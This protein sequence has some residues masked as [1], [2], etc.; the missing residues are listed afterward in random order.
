MLMAFLTRE[1]ILVSR[2]SH[3]FVILFSFYALCSFIFLAVDPTITGWIFLITICPLLALLLSF[4]YLFQQD[5]REGILRDM[6]IA[7][8]SWN[9]L[10][11]A[12]VVML[13]IVLGL[14]QILW[15]AIL[16]FLLPTPLSLPMGLGLMMGNALN[17]SILMVLISALCLRAK[18][19]GGLI[20]LLLLPLYSPSLFYLLRALT[21]NH[22]NTW[23]GLLALTLINGI[24]TA[25]FTPKILKEA[26]RHDA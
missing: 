5:D 18:A 4:P 17:L 3:Q 21:D 14:P 7:G 25:W 20:F 24:L 1:F 13:W 8:V 10:V 9:L 22:E 23:Q 12:K 11:I 6:A 26:L 16:H 2:R 15:F 19:Q